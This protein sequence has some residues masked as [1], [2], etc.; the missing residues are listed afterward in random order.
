M[1]VQFCSG[2][3]FF[4]IIKETEISDLLIKETN[5][6]NHPIN[7]NFEIPSKYKENKEIHELIPTLIVSRK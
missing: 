7:K 6:D 5:L 2:I 4:N 3:N 1:E